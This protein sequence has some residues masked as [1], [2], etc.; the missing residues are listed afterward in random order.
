MRI[1]PT[2]EA[3]KVQLA[4][5]LSLG[6]SFF[7]V[8][9]YYDPTDNKS[10]KIPNVKEWQ[11]TSNFSIKEPKQL[12]ASYA[13][14]FHPETIGAYVI[15]LDDKGVDGEKNLLDALGGPCPEISSPSV[16]VDTPNGRH[17]IFQMEVCD[18]I[19]QSKN[20]L[21]PGVDVRADHS[22]GWL[23]APGSVG[24]SYKHEAGAFIPRRGIFRIYLLCHF[25][26]T[27]Y[28]LPFLSIQRALMYY[29]RLYLNLPPGRYYRLQSKIL[30]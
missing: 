12:L 23:V 16:Y 30:K 25:G 29:L 8:T 11:K 26:S 22:G 3:D 20:A 28:S 15:D 13:Y 10:Y 19:L 27:I 1:T 14:G 6:A 24:Y 4:N 21:L 7:P 18:D 2:I 5:L 9:V 17:V